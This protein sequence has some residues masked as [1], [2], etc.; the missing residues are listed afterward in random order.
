MSAFTLGAPRL[1]ISAV[2]LTLACGYLLPGFILS[3][4]SSSIGAT[5]RPEAQ[6]ALRTSHLVTDHF[7]Y[8]VTVTH[9]RVRAMLHVPGS[10][11]PPNDGGAEDSG[12][13]HVIDLY[14]LFG[15]PMMTLYVSCNETRATIFAP[16]GVL[17][18][19]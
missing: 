7:F 3:E 4:H 9:R 16:P 10:C 19:M 12:R 18:K 15:I 14:T 8:D 1:W 17:E 2:L 5:N 13:V 11:Q 6:K